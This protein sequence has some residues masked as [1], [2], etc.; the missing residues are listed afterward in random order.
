M[1][2]KVW[3]RS[4]CRRNPK[5]HEQIHEQMFPLFFHG[6]GLQVC[7]EHQ[8]VPSSVS[9]KMYPGKRRHLNQLENHADCEQPIQR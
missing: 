9:K 1:H 5:N 4:E 8:L 2:A 6:Q 3:A 7:H